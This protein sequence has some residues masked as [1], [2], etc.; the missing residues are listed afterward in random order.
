MRELYSTQLATA[1]GILTI[2]ITAVF[3]LIQS[4]ELLEFRE[5]SAVRS[6]PA[7]PHPVE[8]RGLCNSCH[9]PKG[10][11]PY[12]SRHAGWSNK[13]CIKCH[14]LTIV[15]SME[16]KGR[17]IFTP[18]DKK[19][20]ILPPLSHPIKGMEK[21]SLCHRPEGNFPYPEDHAGWQDDAC[22]MCH[23]SV[24]NKGAKPR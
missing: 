21:C 18:T 3:A 6:A 9:G 15:D 16:I 4:P 5:K 11:K 22:T 13:I 20:K 14:G 19:K 2:L 23:I 1:V 8:E 10:V 12:P 24:E 7:V 17:G